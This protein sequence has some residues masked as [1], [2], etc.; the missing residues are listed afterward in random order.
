MQVSSR[1]ADRCESVQ[2]EDCRPVRLR[3]GREVTIRRAMPGDAE[4]VQRYMHEGLPEFSDFIMTRPEEFDLSITQERDWIREQDDA[5]GRLALVALADGEVAGT[6]SCGTS[7]RQRVAHVGDVGITLRR[8]FWDSGLGSLMFSTLIEWAESHPVL[9][10]LKL[11]VYPD[12]HPSDRV[13]QEV[14]LQG[15][16][17]CVPCDKV[18]AGT[19]QR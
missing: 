4:A 8:S 18:W 6:L 12:N 17:P 16:G 13:I 2:Q 11:S 10:L 7:A 14:R 5:L 1:V 3:D 9:E 15:S 19:I